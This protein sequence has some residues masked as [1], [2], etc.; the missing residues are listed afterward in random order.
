MVAGRGLGR[1]A[2]LAAALA[3]CA[4]A[5]AAPAA[6]DPTV[7]SLSEGQAV[8]WPG[9]YVSQGRVDDPSL[10]GTEGPCF[11][12][13]LDV[14]SPNAKALRVAISTPDDANGWGLR[15]LDPNGNVVATNSTYNFIAENFDAEVWV[16]KPVPGTWTVQVIAQNV[17]HGS[18]KAR[19]ALDPAAPATTLVG[20]TVSAP[21]AS[22]CSASRHRRHHR[23]RAHSKRTHRRRATRV[24]HRRRHAAHSC[25]VARAAVTAPASAPRAGVVDMPPDLAADAPWHLTFEQPLPMVVVEGSNYTNLAGVHDVTPQIAGQP[26]YSCLPEETIE[27]GAHRC[28]R[29]TSGFAS[30]GPGH[31]EVYGSSPGPVAVNGG[32]L[33][34]VIYRSDGSSYSRPAGSFVFHHIHL[35]YHVVNIAEFHF[36]HVVGSDHHLV[37]AGNVLKQGFCLGNIKMFD[38]R[39]FNQVEVDPNSIDNCQPAPQPDGTWRFYEGMA[40]GWEDAYKWQT[41]GQFIDFGDNPDGY[42]V[43]RMVVNADRHLLESNYAND[44]AYA[45]FQ[46]TGNNIRM[47]ERGYGADPWDPAKTVLDPIIGN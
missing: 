39:S 25:R 36:L 46:V 12:Y 15:L 6:A 29:F 43:L 26:V 42:Y 32:P 28:L 11:N 22:A 24:M 47:I 3:S 10:C 2:L 8:F 37:P 20:A 23:R 16:H 4:G 14:L 18:F 5:A 31:F 45:Y 27:Q 30:L 33:Y 13:R 21:S 7:G 40:E 35:H 19:A 38:W 41:S 1:A 17:Q 9:D 44:Y 34:Q